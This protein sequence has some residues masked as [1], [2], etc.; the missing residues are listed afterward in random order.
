MTAP[1]GSCLDPAWIRSQSCRGLSC[2]E[3]LKELGAQVVGRAWQ[4][5]KS[6]I[7]VFI[8]PLQLQRVKIG[9]AFSDDKNSPRI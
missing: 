5:L 9:Q 7:R 3:W 8:Q 2:E 6:C 1:N 4:Y